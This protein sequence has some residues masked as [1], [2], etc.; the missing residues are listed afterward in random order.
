[1]PVVTHAGLGWGLSALGTRDQPPELLMPN[2]LSRPDR[3]ISAVGPMVG[4]DR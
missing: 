4:L 3:S 1:M 2:V